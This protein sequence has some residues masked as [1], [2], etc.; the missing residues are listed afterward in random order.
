METI[1]KVVGSITM[2]IAFVYVLY[3]PFSL[4]EQD[5]KLAAM[6]LYSIGVICI[7]IFYEEYM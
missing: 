4:W 5:I 3:L 1:L 2:T 6:G 7:V